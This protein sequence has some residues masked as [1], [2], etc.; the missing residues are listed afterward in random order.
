MVKLYIFF[1]E[2]QVC[3]EL[4]QPQG[5]E[6]NMQLVAFCYI[7]EAWE[8]TDWGNYTSLVNSKIPL[9]DGLYLAPQ[10]LHFHVFYFSNSLLASGS[11]D[12]HA[13]I[14]DPQRQKQKCTLRTGH[15]GNLFSVKV[16]VISL[17]PC[18]WCLI[19][20][21][22]SRN[23]VRLEVIVCGHSRITILR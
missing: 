13:I 7:Q 12:L 11:D 9:K 1:G 19:R 3:L 5:F 14:W 10:R 8:F 6:A 17:I 4:F 18:V 16:S 22:S 23:C 15:H 20:A 2:I 21:G